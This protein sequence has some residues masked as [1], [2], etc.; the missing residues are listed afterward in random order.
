MPRARVTI[1]SGFRCTPH[2]QRPKR[3]RQIASPPC[4]SCPMLGRCSQAMCDLEA[5]CRF[6]SHLALSVKLLHKQSSTPRAMLLTRCA[7]T[8]VLNQEQGHPNRRSAASYRPFSFLQLTLEI[9]NLKFQKSFVVQ[10]VANHESTLRLCA[11]ISVSVVL[12]THA[13]TLLLC[14][15]SSEVC[16][17]ELLRTARHN[18]STVLGCKHKR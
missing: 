2:S 16:G 15:Q 4:R 7:R 11:Q 8:M 18:F 3:G 1:C 10:S 6:I 12:L 13:P 9:K 17:G 5:W 14:A